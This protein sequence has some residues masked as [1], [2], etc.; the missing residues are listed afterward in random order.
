MLKWRT[1]L[2]EK[3]CKRQKNVLERRMLLEEEKKE[4]LFEARGKKKKGERE[5]K[6]IV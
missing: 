4:T 1:K 3:I 6:E 5:R 2:V